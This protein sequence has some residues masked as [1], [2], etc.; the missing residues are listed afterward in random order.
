MRNGSTYAVTS[1]SLRI[2]TQVCPLGSYYLPSYA[3]GVRTGINELA[4]SLIN[5]DPCELGRVNDVM[6]Y[7][8]KGHPYVKSAI[9]MACWDILG[10]VRAAN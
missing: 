9:D 8:M 3:E 6:D 1:C 2:H 10:K 7:C 5:L 4:P